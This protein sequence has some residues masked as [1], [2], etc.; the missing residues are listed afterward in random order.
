[1]TL[2]LDEGNAADGYF[3]ASPG[4]RLVCSGERFD[5]FLLYV[6]VGRSA[7]LS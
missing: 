4:F 6:R 5:G 7:T 2:E 1:M 3:E